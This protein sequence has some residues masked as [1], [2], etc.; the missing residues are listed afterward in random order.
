MY[1]PVW[2][3]GV[4]KECKPHPQTIYKVPYY[5][6]KNL[7][8]CNYNFYPDFWI[9]PISIVFYLIG[10][11]DTEEDIYFFYFTKV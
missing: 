6:L 2:P 3:E 9:I 11:K 10:F 7:W 5:E 8:E 4:F 1:I